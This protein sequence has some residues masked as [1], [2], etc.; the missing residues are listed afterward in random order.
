MQQHMARQQKV[1][2]PHDAAAERSAR[3]GATIV[4]QP[5]WGCSSAHSAILLSVVADFNDYDLD[6]SKHQLSDY[7]LRKEWDDGGGHGVG[8]GAGRVS[9]TGGRVSSTGGRVSSAGGR[10]S[11]SSS[12]ASGSMETPDCHAR[13]CL[14]WC[15]SE[16]PI[17]MNMICKSMESASCVVDVLWPTAL[18]AL[19]LFVGA[20]GGF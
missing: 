11:G 12:G 16:I 14:A 5:P 20:W 10:S 13:P 19:A 4:H 3:E 6:A 15:T 8:H 9:S 1:E 18:S 7:E 17:L 2:A